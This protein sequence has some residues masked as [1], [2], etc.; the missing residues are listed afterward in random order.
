MT[1]LIQSLRV[2]T[3]YRDVILILMHNFNIKARLGITYPRGPGPCPLRGARPVLPLYNNIYPNK[4]CIYFIHHIQTTPEI[5][6]YF[7]SYFIKIIINTPLQVMVLYSDCNHMW[8][9]SIIFKT[10]AIIIKFTWITKIKSHPIS[11]D[12]LPPRIPALF[13]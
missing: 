1:I 8:I 2:E 3:Y 12:I 6:P 7:T 13:P 5:S 4:I 9:I 11:A 10:W